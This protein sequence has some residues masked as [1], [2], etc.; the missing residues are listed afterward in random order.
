MDEA[1]F[2]S[3]GGGPVG[4]VGAASGVV[5]PIVAAVVGK[6]EGPAYR[7]AL[8]L[9]GPRVVAEVG[10]RAMLSKRE[11]RLRSRQEAGPVLEEERPPGVKVDLEALA[12]EMADRILR[13]IKREKERRGLY[14]I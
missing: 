5:S 3:V 9:V 6:E 10:Q 2:V 1:G 14:G 8:P 4:E 13:R 11:E 12:M 7:G